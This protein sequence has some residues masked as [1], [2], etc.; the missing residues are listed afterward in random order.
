MN[1]FDRVGRF[2]Y[3]H[4][5][6]VEELESRLTV[7]AGVGRAMRTLKV[8]GDSNGRGAGDD[9]RS[10]GEGVGRDRC[11]QQ[12]IHLWMYDRPPGRHAIGR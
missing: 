8:G 2:S 6:S 10:V 7:E 12:C 5:I 1:N 3:G 4:D 9:D 11:Q